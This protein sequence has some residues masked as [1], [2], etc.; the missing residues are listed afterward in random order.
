MRVRATLLRDR[1]ASS[2]S[3]G[4]LVH[5]SGSRARRPPWLFVHSLDRASERALVLA[6]QH[7]I[8]CVAD[9]VEPSYLAYLG[10]LGLGPAPER[11]IAMSRFSDRAPGRALWARLAE[12]TDALRMVGSLMRAGGPSRLHPSMASRGPFALAAAL[13]IASDTEVR[14]AGG[15]P[16][17]V[18]HAN[19]KHEMRER[20]IALGIPVAEG[21]VVQLRGGRG[22]ATARLRCP[23]PRRRAEAGPDRSRDRAW[24]G[25]CRRVGHRHRGKT[26]D[27]RRRHRARRFPCAPRIART[28]SR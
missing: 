27:G 14:V 11:V 16:A 23:Q 20:A 19:Q 26:G 22:T 28:S 17:I 15:D 4:W 10:E 9:E 1:R 6:H 25:G 12:S 3:P 8:V 2:S 5:S 7:D 21:E 18:E 13:E 24:L